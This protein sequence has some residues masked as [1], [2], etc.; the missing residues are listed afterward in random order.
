MDKH[1][2]QEE[3]RDTEN[4]EAEKDLKNDNQQNNWDSVKVKEK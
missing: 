2:R 4:N 3:R 1:K